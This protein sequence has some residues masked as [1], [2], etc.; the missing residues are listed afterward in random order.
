MTFLSY[1]GR[2]R[3][4]RGRGRGRGRGIP[5]RHRGGWAGA[6]RGGGASSSNK[7]VRPKEEKIEG[8]EASKEPP[9]PETEQIDKKSEGQ[10]A[11]EAARKRVLTMKR[12]R[13]QLVVVHSSSKDELAPPSQGPMMKHKGRHKLVMKTA[14]DRTVE[15]K[16]KQLSPEKGKTIVAAQSMTRLG[17]NKL[18]L[19]GRKTV[20][21]EENLLQ[22]KGKKSSVEMNGDNKAEVSER[23]MEDLNPPESKPEA[24]GKLKKAGPNKLAIAQKHEHTPL[25][26]HPP[27]NSSRPGVAKR[28]KLTMIQPSASEDAG[29]E[30]D[31]EAQDAKETKTAT[32]DKT[33]EKLTD[34]AY[35]ETSRVAPRGG[36][37]RTWTLGGGG[38]GAPTNAGPRN[39]GLVRVQPD[40]TKTRVCPVF[41]KGVECT[42]KY[43]RK[44]HD[45]P[46]EFAMPVC[47]FFQRHGQCLKAEGEC[48]FRHVK[49][50]PRATVCPSFALL[51][52][53]EDQDCAMRHVRTNHHSPP[54]NKADAKRKYVWRSGT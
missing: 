53:C 25:H 50:N 54:Q 27:P 51:G 11:E 9:K 22:L 28:I 46:K 5:G 49:V 43:C 44:R 6:G 26:K 48:M 17:H 41:L 13:N 3:G 24:Q 4:G 47:S 40:E 1:T 29:S 15:E 23:N 20:A 7:W 19:G 10:Q 14:A 52:F 34:F 36:Q 35:R 30:E 42:D 45:V 37:H 32:P 33:T 38:G 18:V 21:A 16:K 31:E 8:D 12:S 2:G 39:M